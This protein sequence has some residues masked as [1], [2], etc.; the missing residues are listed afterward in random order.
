[1]QRN[2]LNPH[3]SNRRQGLN[4]A[5][6]SQVPV[7]PASSVSRKR[8]RVDG[9]SSSRTVATRRAPHPSRSATPPLPTRYPTHPSFPPPETSQVHFQGEAI[10]GETLRRVRLLARDNLT[11][12]DC[13]SIDGQSDPAAFDQLGQM[14]TQAIDNFTHLQHSR[15]GIVCL[16]QLV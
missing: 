14:L 6:T 2:L 5:P 4:V 1:M 16:V 11:I 13:V 8:T 9:D 3:V 7:D 15:G 10:R 12:E